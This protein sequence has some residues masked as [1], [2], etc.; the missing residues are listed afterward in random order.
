MSRTRPFL[1]LASVALSSCSLS[2]IDGGEGAPTVGS[3]TSLGVVTG[4]IYQVDDM[5][6]TAEALDTH[7]GPILCE[8]ASLGADWIRIQAPWYATTDAT[9]RFIVDEAHRRGLRV[10][11]VVAD[12][13]SGMACVGDD[14]PARIETFARA[15]VA[16]LDRLATTTFA[17]HEPDAWEITNEP[18]VNDPAC[19]G[20]FRVGGRALASVLRAVW[21]WK[22]GRGRRELIVSG[23]TLNIDHDAC[24]DRD[25][26][27]CLDGEEVW[28]D[29]YLYA[30]AM[31]DG[32][33]PFD[34]FGIHPYQSHSY[35]EADLARGCAEDDRGGACVGLPQWEAD[36]RQRLASLREKLDERFGAPTRFFASE[37][38]WQVC[39]GR[40]MC[41]PSEALAAEGLRRAVAAFDASGAVSV[42]LWYSARDVM[43]R[44]AAEE[45]ASFGLRRAWDGVR[46]PIRL[47]LA[48]SFRDEAGGDPAACWPSAHDIGVGV[49]QDGAYHPAIADCFARNGSTA[50][51]GSPFGN[52]GTAYV[53]RWGPAAVQDLRGGY[54]GPSLCVHRDGAPAAVMVRGD[55]RLEYIR[56]GGA[57]GWL[58][59]PLADEVT[60]V[61]GQ[62]QRY[63]H[64]HIAWDA[65]S[66]GFLARPEAGCAE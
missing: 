17:G 36:L 26:D 46:H 15:Y 20:A 18:N 66:D 33:R 4:A 40:P 31:T 12:G 59:F 63:E 39:A 28:W 58:G 41:A 54:L 22:V 10:L 48:E 50:G 19:G 47:D 7:A 61:S 1:L 55:I 14:D 49:D 35:R 13:V 6:A 27:G 53:H 65:A 2:G 42:A 5:S 60:T 38:G 56:Q 3:V 21:D 11:V 62:C 8:L 57:L 64:G 29:E 43:P 9:Y 30:P 52:G 16:G 45:T 37:F 24:S 51:A 32:P 44:D 25:A 23:G 34:L